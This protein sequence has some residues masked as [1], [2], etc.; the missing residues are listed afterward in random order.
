L[1]KGMAQFAKHRP[2]FQLVAMA[3]SQGYCY[4]DDGLCS[5]TI[6]G[7]KTMADYPESG[8]STEVAILD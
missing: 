8:V 5:E 1:G 3:D 7:L 2:D 4:S 6:Q